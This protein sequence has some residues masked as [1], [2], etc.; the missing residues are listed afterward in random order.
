MLPIS[1]TFLDDDTFVTGHMDQ[2]V[3]VF[4]VEKNKVVKPIVIDLKGLAKN[5]GMF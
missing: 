4:K 1:S 5:S 3:C 2:A